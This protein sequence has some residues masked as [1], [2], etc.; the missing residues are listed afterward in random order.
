MK[1]LFTPSLPK[2]APRHGPAL[3][4][5]NSARQGDHLREKG[6]AFFDDQ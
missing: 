6:D 4:G 5:L 1:A 2:A 3:D